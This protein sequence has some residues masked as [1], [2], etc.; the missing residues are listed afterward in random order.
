M[1]KLWLVVAFALLGTAAFFN[2]AGVSAREPDE[3]RHCHYGTPVPPTPAP[4]LTP[5]PVPVVSRRQLV[6]V[7]HGMNSSG[8]DFTRSLGS[9]FIR[10]DWLILAPTLPYS[11][12]YLDPAVIMAD[13]LKFAKALVVEIDRLSAETPLKPKVYLFG[14]SRGAQLAERFTLLYP[15]RVA[16]VALLGGGSY[17]LPQPLPFPYGIGDLP[18]NTG[19]DFNGAALR[20]VRFWVGVGENDRVESEVPR[21]FDLYLGKN[22]VERASILAQALWDFGAKAQLVTFPG[23]G[24]AVTTEIVRQVYKFLDSD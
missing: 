1:K 16:R 11:S 10:S 13:D 12:G 17:T 22:R 9:G 23:E 8:E 6:I 20:E 15:E 3:D 7:L 2:T 19:W 21:A 4:T 24:H 18:T 5:T 14:F